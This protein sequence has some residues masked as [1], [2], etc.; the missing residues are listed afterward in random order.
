MPSLLDFPV[1]LVR[2][3]LVW[4]HRRSRSTLRTCLAVALLVIAI[5][6]A[7][8]WFLPYPYPEI[9]DEFSYLLGAD[10]FAQGRLANPSH[11]LADHFEAVHTLIRPSYA[12]KYPM[13]QAAMLAFGQRVAGH[14]H[15]GVV[16]SIAM[17]AAASCWA[18]RAWVP[19]AW[20]L[21]G[22]LGVAL[23]YGTFHYWVRSYWG[24]GVALFGTFLVIGAYGWLTLHHRTSAG[25]AALG[26]GLAALFCSR[27]YEGAIVGI[28]FFAALVA[29][30][31]RNRTAWAAAWRAGIPILAVIATVVLLIQALVNEAVTGTPLRL[32]YMEHGRQYALAPVLWILPPNLTPRKAA[33]EIAALHRWELEVYE[34]TLKLPVWKRLL[35]FSELRGVFRW[36]KMIILATVLALGGAVMYRASILIPALLI[37]LLG[38]SLET[39]MLEHYL[40]PFVAVSCSIQIIGIAAF[41]AARGWRRPI[42][43]LLLGLFFMEPVARTAR[44]LRN[45]AA[46]S[47]VSRSRRRPIEE[48]LRTLGGHHV[49]IVR[50]GERSDPHE[51]WVYNLARIDDASI[52][53]A[54]DLGTEAN[55]KL[56]A[57]YPDRRFW[58]CLPE[59]GTS[60]VPLIPLSPP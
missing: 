30:S 10:T 42:A 31:F 50:S 23:T 40:A 35:R 49:V 20:A 48:K 60:E 33:Q 2:R 4:L 56:F 13:G 9:H 28:F 37:A 34:N 52:I 46:P 32:P 8:S 18:L 24:G 15:W 25:F 29:H 5:Q 7:A 17:A 12:S 14:P 19:P 26:L 1:R 21:L 22:S 3:F 44:F 11:P 36:P 58:L 16:F 27:P 39:F 45:F 55:R 51:A 47:S 41:F 59:R 53:W 38:P 43:I 57:Y 6:F 54:R